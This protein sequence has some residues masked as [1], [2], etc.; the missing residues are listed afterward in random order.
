[1]DRGYHFDPE[2]K[3]IFSGANLRA[4]QLPNGRVSISLDLT[5]SCGEYSASET[6][7]WKTSE[8]L[9]RASD[10]EISPAAKALLSYDRVSGSWRSDLH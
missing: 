9:E 5:E 10:R 6:I 2:I 7:V 4:T 8:I 3:Q 1:M